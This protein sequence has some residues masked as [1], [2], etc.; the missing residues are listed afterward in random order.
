MKYVTLK[1]MNISGNR[2]EYI[3]EYPDEMSHYIADPSQTLFIELPTQYNL[4]D[5]P[6]ALLVVPFVGSMMCVTML[7]GYGIKVPELDKTFYES[8]P[9]IK[10]AFHKMFPYAEFCFEINAEK[11]TDCSYEIQK[12]PSVFFSG[13]LDATSALIEHIDEKPLMINIYGGDLLLTD[14]DSHIALEKY[15]KK[16]ANQIGNE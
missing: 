7:L 5:V 13:G 8:V 6:E 14:T 11:L 4:R 9:K 15:F 12:V 10:N 2:C 16:L 1:N 3:F